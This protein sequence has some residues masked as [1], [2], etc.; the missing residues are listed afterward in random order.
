VVKEKKIYKCMFKNC[1]WTGDDP[2]IHDFGGE[3]SYRCKRTN[4][5]P[6][7]LVDEN[8]TMTTDWPEGD[9]IISIGLDFFTAMDLL[10]LTCRIPD[11]EKELLKKEYPDAYNL[12]RFLD[13]VGDEAFRYIEH[14]PD[15]RLKT[16]TSE[17]DND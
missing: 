4:I 17:K 2:R 9:D 7:F 13:R 8:T 1:G 6:A 10:I 12:L 5:H 3:I 11:E 16:L 14:Y 15:I